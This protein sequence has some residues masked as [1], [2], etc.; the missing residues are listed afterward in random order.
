MS[1]GTLPQTVFFG[2]IALLPF[3][4]FLLSSVSEMFV[5]IAMTALIFISFSF[6]L[7]VWLDFAQWV[8]DRY[9]NPKTQAA[10][11][12]AGDKT[13][14]NKDGTPQLTGDDS[15][16]VL[17]YQRSIVAEGKSRLLSKPIQPIDDGQEVYELPKSFTRED[18][19]KLKENKKEIATGV[20]AYAN[21]HKNDARYVE[22]NEQ[23]EARERA[24]Q[25]QEN[26]GKKGKKKK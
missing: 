24:L 19:K 1:V 13:I 17:E 18:L 11:K 3:A 5:S 12:Q 14:Y 26:K 2:V 7:L 15:A 21:E 6:A 8:F 4:A 16:S 22:Y 10:K 25:E 9:V 23:F 20:E